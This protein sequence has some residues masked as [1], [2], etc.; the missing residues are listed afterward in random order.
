MNK[1]LSLAALTG[2]VTASTCPTFETQKNIDGSRYVGN[3]FEITRDADFIF[4]LGSQCSTAHY[5]PNQKG[6]IDVVNRSWALYYGANYFALKGEAKPHLEEG[7]LT[8]GFFGASIE[9]DANY[10]ILFTD[11][12][13]A[14]V[15]DCAPGPL[16]TIVE[17]MWIL[18]R[19]NTMSDEKLAFL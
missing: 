14:I 6:N 2:A 7:N 18:S 19:E 4:E 3:W 9:G 10:N 17:Q 1:Y 15:Y 5:T 12:D 13:N 8:V 11:Y 16:G